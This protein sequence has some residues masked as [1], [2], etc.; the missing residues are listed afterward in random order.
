M[1]DNTTQEIL[2]EGV[3]EA[4]ARQQLLNRFTTATKVY[5]IIIENEDGTYLVGGNLNHAIVAAA[6]EDLSKTHDKMIKNETEEIEAE[7]AAFKKQMQAEQGEDFNPLEFEI[8]MNKFREEKGI[9]VKSEPEMTEQ[10]E[11]KRLQ[12]MVDFTLSVLSTEQLNE[13]GIDKVIAGFEEST[14]GH[15][16]QERF[17]VLNARLKQKL[18]ERINNNAPA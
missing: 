18:M 17:K 9:L 8:G 1:S 2:L 10:E 12:R 6:M 5:Y 11:D 15:P 13:A 4:D 7:I 16:G 3:T 14:K